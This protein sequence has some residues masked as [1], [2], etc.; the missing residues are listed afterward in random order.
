M[1]KPSLDQLLSKV[2]SK[3]SLVVAAAKRARTITE[4]KGQADFAGIK[5]VTLALKEIVDGKIT[6][7]KTKEGIK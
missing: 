6:Y 2:D 5:S 7:R 1:N 3:Y 4:E